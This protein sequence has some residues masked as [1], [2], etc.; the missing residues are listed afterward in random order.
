MTVKIEVKMNSP[1]DSPTDSRRAPYDDSER[2]ST[3]NGSE[4]LK[5]TLKV[6]RETI[7]NSE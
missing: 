7:K 4:D 3:Y 6:K 1:T 2:R 5:A